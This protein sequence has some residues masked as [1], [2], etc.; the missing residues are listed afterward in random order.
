[1]RTLRVDIDGLARGDDHEIHVVHR[2]GPQQRLIA[3][4]HGSG[5]APAIFEVN[6]HW[7][8]IGNGDAVTIR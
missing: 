4:N 8:T 3:E 2:D 6:F 7:P 5:E 1:M